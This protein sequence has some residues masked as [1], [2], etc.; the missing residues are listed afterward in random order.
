M[1][2]SELMPSW[3]NLTETSE[4]AKQEWRVILKTLKK[5]GLEGILTSPTVL[6]IGGG[7]GEFSKYLNSNDIKCL[8]IDK[9]EGQKPDPETTKIRADAYKMPF[10]DESFDI[11]HERGAFDD[12]TYPHKF[13]QL[14]PEVAR[15]IKKGGLLIVN[16]FQK[17]P[18]EI[19]NKYF[20]KLASEIMNIL[21][22]WQKK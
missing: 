10:A 22:I 2:Q 16:D 17:P 13:E 9:R 12:S 15:V 5:L 19:L 20:T 4:D 11:I 1:K 8:T 3:E 6:D 7:R 14:F 21:T 18:E